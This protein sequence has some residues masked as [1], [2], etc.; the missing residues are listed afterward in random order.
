[1]VF[2]EHKTK[3][4]ELT[5]QHVDRLH[6][7][8]SHMF[9]P[10][11]CE[12]FLVRLK[13]HADSFYTDLLNES[14]EKQQC[15][16]KEISSLRAEA[17]T[18]THLLHEPMDIGDR[19]EDMPL[20]LWQLKLD[21]S[22]EHLR[23]GL[24]KRR[25]EIS[26]M[27]QKQEHLCKELGEQPLPLLDDPLPTVEEMG[28]FR[29]HLDQLRDQ[30]V[31][32]VE[33]MKELRQS[34][35]QD[36][37]VLGCLPQ[38][39][40]E[41][42]L[43]NQVN[44]TLTP[45]TFKSL[46]RM[47]AEFAEQ[48]KELHEQIDDMRQKIHV[49]WERLQD[50]DEYA[51][52]R[53]RE[54]TAYTQHTYDVLREELHRCQALRRQNLKVF[55]DRLRVEIK[56][57]WELTLKGP[58]ECKRFASFYNTHLTEED[59][60]LHE[61]ELDKLKRL[62][63]GNKKIYEMYSNRGEMWARMIALEA[64]ANDPN[65]F[66]NRGG[67][68]L[69]EQKERKAITA[70]LPK[71]E[72]QIAELVEE[73]VSQAKVPFLVNGV[74]ILEQM[75]ADWENLRQPKQAPPLSGKKEVGHKMMPPSAPL[76]PKALKGKPGVYGSTSSLKKTPSKMKS[77]SAAKSTGNLQKRRH[78]NTTNNNIENTNE[79][80][81]AAAK[82]NLIASLECNN[83]VLGTNT[84]RKLLKSP[85][86]KVRVLD[87]SLRREKVNGRPSIG[88]RSAHRSRPIPQVRVQP[89]SSEDNQSDDSEDVVDLLSP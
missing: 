68:L 67:Q 66:N 9:E 64:K 61:L 55:I 69:K 36:M 38:S 86:K 57:M 44:H 4:L 30:R 58:A 11:T 29:E 27:L 43:L 84:Q 70:K 31:R 16:Q 63:E 78:P 72:Q 54:S 79:P 77:P 60:E 3:I 83:G 37:K 71:I 20:V 5:S 87:Y 80:T 10:K 17:S 28:Y 59:L 26:D 39:D 1:M 24:A 8:W 15:I 51:Q 21:E 25:A 48:V 49:L 2:V 82:R 88:S 53:V 52:R 13:D 56:A 74:N 34:I 32:L 18:L 45:D 7:L 6:E 42:R 40:A 33:E 22:I 46:R 65:R 76:T 89:P 14:R 19:P 50:T 23:D 47:Q 41:E 35:K 62:Y 85:Q 73:Y 12:E 81:A 75:A